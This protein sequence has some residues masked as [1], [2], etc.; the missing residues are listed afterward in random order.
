MKYKLWHKREMGSPA[1]SVISSREMSPAGT[2]NS[3][4]SMI[5]SLGRGLAMIM[6][7]PDDNEFPWWEFK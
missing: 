1:S 5:R 7:R 4:F 2:K 6:F 3:I